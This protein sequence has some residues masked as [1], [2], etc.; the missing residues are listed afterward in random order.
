MGLCYEPSDAVMQ[1]RV[2]GGDSEP[3]KFAELMVGNSD[4][5]FYDYE[6]TGPG[7]LSLALKVG[8]AMIKLKF[9]KIG[10]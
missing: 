3:L 10:D 1:T 9:D 2:P 8:D 6:C 7:K 5:Q 4:Q